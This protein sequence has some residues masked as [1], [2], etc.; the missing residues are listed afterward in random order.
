MGCGCVFAAAAVNWS[1]ELEYILD[2]FKA[3]LARS[4]LSA[5]A[6]GAGGAARGRVC[7][8]RADCRAAG[9]HAPH[10]CRR[11][12]GRGADAA[13]R[14]DHAREDLPVAH[15]APRGA[16]GRRHRHGHDGRAFRCAAGLSRRRLSALGGQHDL[17]RAACGAHV[18]ALGSRCHGPARHRG[19]GGRPRRAPDE[20]RRHDEA[21]QHVQLPQSRHAGRV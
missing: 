18:R 14:H 10:V 16:H 20:H 9:A 17:R 8:P 12:E 1:H 11:P 6:R 5:R 3:E 4:R 13:R 19:R 15:R 21:Q 7:P 2:N